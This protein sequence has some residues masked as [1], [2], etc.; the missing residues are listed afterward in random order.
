[1]NACFAFDQVGDKLS[2][3]SAEDIC[4][5]LMIFVALCPVLLCIVYLL[6][7]VDGLRAGLPYLLRFSPLD[8]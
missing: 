5:C 6:L 7:M 3:D 8:C 1:V 2:W 4:G